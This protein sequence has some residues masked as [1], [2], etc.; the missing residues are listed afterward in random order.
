MPCRP[1]CRRP[2]TWAS[3]WV[4]VGLSPTAT[5]MVRFKRRL[6]SSMNK[7]SRSEIL[8]RVFNQQPKLIAAIC[9]THNRRVINIIL[10]WGLDQHRRRHVFSAVNIGMYLNSQGALGWFLCGKFLSNFTSKNRPKTQ[11][12][13]NCPTQGVLQHS[14]GKVSQ[15]KF[16]YTI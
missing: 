9:S 6:V 16:N 1:R 2:L 5:I 3:M 7:Y 15:G 12:T 13:G 8:V 10:P 4:A 14:Q 11:I